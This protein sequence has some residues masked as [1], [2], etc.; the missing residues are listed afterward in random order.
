MPRSHRQAGFTLVEMM[1]AL[2]VGV[3]SV[4]VA[5]KVA[6]VVIRQAA[7]GQ[8]ATDFNSRSRLLG[9]QL[10]ADLR[11]AGFG[12]TGAV[13][14]D[15]TIAPWNAGMTIAVNGKPA[16][17][18]VSGV[19]NLAAGTISGTP[20]QPN[21]DA[22]M[23]VVP[24]AGLSGVTADWTAQGSNTI[25]LG[26]P[27]TNPVP[28]VQPLAS[29]TTGMVYVV[30]HTAPNGAGR[31]QL[32]EMQGIAGPNLTT[33]GVL[34]FTL[35]P[36]SSVMCARLSTYWLDANGWLHRTDFGTGAAPTPLGGG[37]VFVDANQVGA[38]LIAPGVADLQI[39]YRF[40]SEVYTSAGL[41]LP[42]VTNLPAQWAFEGQGA[43]INGMIT[44]DPANWFEARRVRFNAL[45]RTLR[46]V[47]ARTPEVRNR[48]S[49]ED[50][51]PT[52]LQRPLRAEWVTTVEALTNLRYFDYGAPQGVAPQPF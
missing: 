45:V 19:N 21:S 50:G 47:D 16:I 49:R 33:V 44:G 11:A 41:G 51:V 4:V 15:A 3:I 52:N 28:A 23:V 42:A 24:N 36:G 38:D 22:M 20:I 8:Q 7:Q 12:S 40:S 6:Q 26:L 29:C 46:S 25:I 35:A 14:V 30:D 5:A 17:P 43:N 1:V 39:A 18:A 31:A 13:A 48:L 37:P 34:Q 9:R 32:L 10:R 27:P 2:L